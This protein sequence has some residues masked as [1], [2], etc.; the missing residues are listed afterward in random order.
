MKKRETKTKFFMVLYAVSLLTVSLSVSDCSDKKNDR[1]RDPVALPPAEYALS[2]DSLPFRFEVSGHARFS[3]RKTREGEYFCD[4]D[5][6]GLKAHVYCTWHAVPPGGFRKLAEESRKLAY[7]HSSMADAIREKMY[8]NDSTRVYGI[9]YDL[10][11]NVA[12]PVQLGLTDSTRYFFNAS[13]YLD[14]PARSDSAALLREYVRKDLV[15][16][17][18]T[19]QAP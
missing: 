10:E 16:L 9:L 17:M 5:Y 11:G 15:R 18:E 8:S 7:Q 19:F 2:P 3:A 6:P 1:K 13:L 14:V 12:T 4:L